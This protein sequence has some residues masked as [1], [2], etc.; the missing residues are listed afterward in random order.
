MTE[1]HSPPDARQLERLA[2]FLRL[3]P[4]DGPLARLLTGAALL[5]TPPTTRAELASDVLYGAGQIAHFLY[6]SNKHRRK[7]YRLVEAEKL[8]HFRLGNHICSRKCRLLR[9]IEDQE[10]R[11]KE[12]RSQNPAVDLWNAKVRS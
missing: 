11:M 2:A 10:N 1:T 6:G 5:E 12:T 4:E 7:V 8:P 3:I 9:W